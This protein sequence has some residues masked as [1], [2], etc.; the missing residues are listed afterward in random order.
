MAQV[1]ITINEDM[2]KLPE[3]NYPEDEVEE[4]T[5]EVYHH[6]FDNYYGGGKSI[7]NSYVA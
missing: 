6:V 3:D 1:R 4:K 2:W 5:I 7:Y